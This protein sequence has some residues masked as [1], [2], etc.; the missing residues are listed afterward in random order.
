MGQLE[1]ISLRFVALALSR[2]GQYISSERNFTQKRAVKSNPERRARELNP[3]ARSV[4]A[5]LVPVGVG[6][7][8]PRAVP[9]NALATLWKALNPRAEDSSELMAL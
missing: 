8:W 4:L 5:P 9:F 3:P 7:D 1:S 2:T 6:L